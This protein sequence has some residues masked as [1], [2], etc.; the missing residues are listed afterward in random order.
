VDAAPNKANFVD[1]EL[2]ME[3]PPTLF[4]PLLAMSPFGE[5]DIVSMFR[6][7]GVR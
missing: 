7:A 5:E 2:K 4:G 6:G 1:S 3:V